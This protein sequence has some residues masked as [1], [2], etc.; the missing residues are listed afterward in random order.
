VI[1]LPLDVSTSTP[2]TSS[3]TLSF[4]FHENI[5]CKYDANVKP[6]CG[7]AFKINT[8]PQKRLSSAPSVYFKIPQRAK[9]SPEKA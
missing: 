9:M 4:P 6:V 5:A 1:S 8:L 2:T 3:N 7:V